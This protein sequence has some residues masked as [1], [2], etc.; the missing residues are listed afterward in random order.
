MCARK[1]TKPL[2][3][4]YGVC[5]S[6]LG[7]KRADEQTDRQTDSQKEEHS[8]AEATLP[9]RDR[10]V[11]LCVG[12]NPFWRGRWSSISQS[13]CLKS[14]I[15]PALST[16]RR[17]SSGCAYSFRTY[18]AFHLRF[19]A[20]YVNWAAAAGTL[21]RVLIANHKSSASGISGVVLDWFRS[22]SVYILKACG[23]IIQFQ[24]LIKRPAFHGLKSTVHS[25]PAY[26]PPHIS[27][28]FQLWN[29]LTSTSTNIKTTRKEKP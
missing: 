22:Q 10:L 23:Q 6:G 3:T 8:V 24:R 27:R 21:P 20:R 1:C 13:M 5:G 11:C 12:I 29:S 28:P 19:A 25:T 7:K 14:L 15:S 17:G 4:L 16:F 26:P 18:I 2:K 9:I